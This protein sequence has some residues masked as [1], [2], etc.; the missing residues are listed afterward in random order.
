MKD[1]IL[2]FYSFLVM[3]EQEV[4]QDKLLVNYVLYS[5]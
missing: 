5:V 4:S 2:F 1:N 3:L